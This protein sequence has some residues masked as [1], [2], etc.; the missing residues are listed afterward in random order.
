MESADVATT[1]NDGNS[2]ARS[3]VGRLARSTVLLMVAFGIAKAIS[4][5]QV[6]IIADVFG[7]GAEWDAFVTA[8]RIPE[9]L[10][11]L[12]G[13]GALGYAFIPVFGG[14]LAQEKREEAWQ[15]ASHVMNTI[16]LVT[17]LLSVL[18]FIFAPWLIQVAIAPGFDAEQVAQTAA[19]MR[20]L[21]ISTLLFSI[22][23]IFQ[24]ILHSHNHFLLPALAPILLDVGILFGVV[25]LIGP[26][27]VYGVAWGAVLG[28]AMHFGIQVPGLI[29][30][31]MR[32]WPQFGWNDPRLRE[33][34]RLMIPRLLGLAVVSFNLYLVPNNIGSRLG[35]GAVSAFDWGWRLMQIPETLIGSAMGFVIFPT[36]AALSGLHDLRGKRDAMNGALRFILVATV[37]AAVGLIVLGRPLV[38]LL[39]RGAFDAEASNL[40]FSTLQF[41][42]LG[43]IVHSALEIVARSFYADKDTIT[44]LYAAVIAAAINLGLALLLTGPLGV[45]GLALANS[46]AVGFEV[47]VLIVILRRRWAGIGEQA[48]LSTLLRAGIAS[49]AMAAAILLLEA[50]LGG[51]LN[52]LDLGLIGEVAKLG[53]EVLLGVAV[54]AVVALLLGM[55]EIRTVIAALLRRAGR[56]QAAAAVE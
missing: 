43:L 28:A 54:Y 45:G 50:I 14:L 6:F 47:I 3:D 7:V 35:E 1:E 9:L 36:L 49:A 4:L 15:L 27:G 38:G 53:I 31:R 25:F 20:I 30:Y 2:A 18:V 40:V 52:S 8:N 13:G 39:E 32:W 51:V 17:A 24:G 42:A 12:I 23:G 26:L 56:K 16:F 21:L 34:I 48:L 33:V 46:V 44:P 41:F 29:H 19:L 37:P 11:I 10:V 5:V 22:S 55:T